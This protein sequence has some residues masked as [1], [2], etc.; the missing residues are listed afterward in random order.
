[1][2]Y[3]YVFE[4]SNNIL[5]PPHPHHLHRTPRTHPGAC[6]CSCFRCVGFEQTHY[7]YDKNESVLV[8]T[9]P[10]TSPPPHR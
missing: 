4:L 9:T 3:M 8:P 6:T 5:L 10:P 1:M 2:T 7:S